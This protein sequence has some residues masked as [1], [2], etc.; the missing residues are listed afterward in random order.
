MNI[1]VVT[2]TYNNRFKLLEQV[3]RKVKALGVES[4]IVVD[5]N[6]EMES[7]NNLI[8]LE[9]ELQPYLKVIYL[10]E[11]IGSAGGYSVGLKEFYNNNNCEFVWLLD[12]DNLPEEKSLD[13]IK[14][15][16]QNMS[17][18][19]KE[20][21]TALLSARDDREIYRTAVIEKD[22]NLVIGSPNGFLG[23]SIM[24]IMKK[25]ILASKS[26]SEINNGQVSAAYYGGLFMNKK[27]VREIGFPNENFFLYSDDIEFSNR[28]IRKGGQ[29]I[30]LFNSMIRDID[31]KWHDNKTK[32]SILKLPHITEKNK[33][34]YYYQIRNR[35]YI[36]I[37][38]LKNNSL[39]YYINKIIYLFVLKIVLLIKK[40]SV[41]RRVIEL[42]ISDGIRASLGKKDKDYLN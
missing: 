42:A 1:C 7:R 39:L 12:D 5:N 17:E 29:I 8:N 22:P 13:I 41:N 23:F 16:W 11:N 38:F 26:F 25:Q 36:E 32:I 35:V 40:D 15:F 2:V 31:D 10:K 4:I 14:D 34:R 21:N 3:V 20:E 37:N 28:I 6:S 33:D 30:V 18:K 19:N 24:K 9:L 27:L